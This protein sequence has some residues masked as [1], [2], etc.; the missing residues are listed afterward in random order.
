MA[1][2]ERRAG[3]SKLTGRPIDDNGA[4]DLKVEKTDGH[5]RMHVKDLKPFRNQVRRHTPR[6]I[7]MIGD[8]LQAVGAARSIVLDENDEIL[9]GAGTIEAAAERGLLNVRVIESDGSEVIAVRRRGLSESQKVTLALYDNRSADLAEY[10]LTAM[11]GALAIPGVVSSNFFNDAE[12][13][14]LEDRELAHE[15]GEH[16]D[17]PKKADTVPSI[18]KGYT[19]LAFVVS[20][21]ADAEIRGILSAYKDA[22]SLKTL[23]EAL[24]AVCRAYKADQK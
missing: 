13:R 23:A 3:K 4:I 9:A 20:D 18:P 24:L 22:H 16:R 19:S 15:L 6:N 21:E 17:G 5:Q 11:K 12:L 10:D 8:S 2:T 1:K 14:Q 7:G